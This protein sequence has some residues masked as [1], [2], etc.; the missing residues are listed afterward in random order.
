MQIHPLSASLIS[1]SLMHTLACTLLKASGVLGMMVA[2]AVQP[3][4]THSAS[5]KR[6]KQQFSFLVSAI[7]S[8]LRLLKNVKVENKKKKTTNKTRTVSV[9]CLPF[10]P[11]VNSN[12]QRDWLILKPASVWCLPHTSTDLVGTCMTVLVRLISA[13]LCL[14]TP[15][16][17]HSGN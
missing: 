11:M 5:Q 16:Y 15:F 3:V 1:S 6:N 7:W 17:P 10:S 14:S 4:I 2:S 13:C 8:I 12:S 9:G